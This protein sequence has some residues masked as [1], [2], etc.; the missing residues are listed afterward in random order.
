LWCAICLKSLKIGKDEVKEAEVTTTAEDVPTTA[1]G[2]KTTT[3]TMG[4]SSTDIQRL[5]LLLLSSHIE[6]LYLGGDIEEE[7]KQ[8]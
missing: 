2:T 8:L 7:F 6:E 3:T 1:T 5:K 4:W